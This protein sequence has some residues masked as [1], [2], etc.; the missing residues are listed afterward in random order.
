[1]K[2]EALKAKVQ[3]TR[4]PSVRLSGH[5]PRHKSRAMMLRNLPRDTSSA[6]PSLFRQPKEF[7]RTLGQV[8][9]SQIYL[10]GK[11]SKLVSL[12]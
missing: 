5:P 10:T 9:Y 7:G 8:I 4:Y 3:D 11:A 2:F 12:Q 6:S 1:M